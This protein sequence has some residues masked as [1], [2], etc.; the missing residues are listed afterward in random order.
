MT[1]TAVSPPA[2]GATAGAGGIRELRIP[3]VHAT[4]ALR[5]PVD[6]TGALSG[7]DLRHT[8]LT[9]LFQRTTGDEPYART[10]VAGPWSALNVADAGDAEQTMSRVFAVPARRRFAATAWVA[11]FASAPDPAL[12]RL[13]GYRGPVTATSSDRADGQPRWRASAAL[14]GDPR[15]AWLGSIAD[16]HTPWLAWQTPRPTTVRALRL[17]APSIPVARP[18]QV[19]LI[20]PGGATPAL[21][22]DPGGRVALPARGERAALSSHRSSPPPPRRR[23]S[24]ADRRA[25]GIAEVHG[26]RG[27]P[28]IRAAG[29]HGAPCGAVRVRVERRRH[30]AC[31][32]PARRLPSRRAAPCSRARAARR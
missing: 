28:A 16:G 10:V 2:P 11:P 9:Y 7:A 22:V 4:E 1:I 32:S 20:W 19:R 27:L 25:V 15:T 31:A 5:L 30:A 13:A 3:G 24:A 6:A 12:D 29:F 14:D 21:P 17:L 23:A 18:T 8:G 26:V